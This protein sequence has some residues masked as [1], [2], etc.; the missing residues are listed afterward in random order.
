MLQYNLIENHILRPPT[1]E[2]SRKF[3]DS[4]IERVEGETSTAAQ[5][6]RG[7]DLERHLNKSRDQLQKFVDRTG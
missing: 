2:L 7:M 4:N 1:N 3:R 5:S 6:K